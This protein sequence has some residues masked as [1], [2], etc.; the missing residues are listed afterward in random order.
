MEEEMMVLSPIRRS[1][2]LVLKRLTLERT[3]ATGKQ[4][5]LAE[6]VEEA[7]MD[8]ASREIKKNKG[9]LKGGI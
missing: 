3:K 5:F 6:V 4:V 7:I 9:G 8:L 2:W 1:V